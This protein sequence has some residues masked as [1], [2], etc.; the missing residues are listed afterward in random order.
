MS[1]I[2]DRFSDNHH[3]AIFR[4]PGY[5]IQRNRDIQREESILTEN[6]PTENDPVDISESTPRYRELSPFGSLARWPMLK[7]TMPEQKMEP[8][9]VQTHSEGVGMQH[10]RPVASERTRTPSENEPSTVENAR[11]EYR[12]KQQLDVH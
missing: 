7:S 3:T 4:Q 5:S 11:T 2:H 1:D 9:Q 8:A 10:T 6:L 12:E